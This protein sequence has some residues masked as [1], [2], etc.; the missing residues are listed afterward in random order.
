MFCWL[1]GSPFGLPVLFINTC[2]DY[3][4]EVVS[5]G[6]FFVVVVEYKCFSKERSLFWE[7]ENASYRQDMSN[8]RC[9]LCSVYK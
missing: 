1:H 8:C 5:K 3:P 7:A 9:H 2:K 4:H 6:F